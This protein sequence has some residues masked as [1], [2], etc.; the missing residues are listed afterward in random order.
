MTRHCRALVEEAVADASQSSRCDP[1]RD[2]VGCRRLSNGPQLVD[3]P[4]WLMIAGLLIN[5]SSQSRSGTRGHGIKTQQSRRHTCLC[6]HRSHITEQLS[7]TRLVGACHLDAID[8]N[9]NQ[10]FSDQ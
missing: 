2:G 3:D 1:V 9:N 10:C 8:V 4:L 5:L 6:L 7:G